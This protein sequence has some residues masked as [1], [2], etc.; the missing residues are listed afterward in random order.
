MTSNLYSNVE[1]TSK[2]QFTVGKVEAGIA[3]LLSPM[4]HLVEFPSQILPQ[5]VTTGSTVNITI[6]RNLIEEHRQLEEFETLQN[7]I[8]NTFTQ[9]P[10]PP[11]LSL[12]SVTQSSIVVEWTSLDLKHCTLHG[13]DIYKNG[14][15]LSIDIPKDATS[16]KI[17]GLDVAHT[18]DLWLIARTSAG[19]LTSNSIQVETH[20]MEN[21]TGITV[22]FGTFA[23]R[24]EVEDLVLLLDRIGAR[25]TDDL[26]INNTH[27]VC[28][29]PRGT[30]F[31]QAAEWNIPIV[32]P[33]F[34]KACEVNGR[35]QSASS[36]YISK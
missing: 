5:G 7:D 22:S 10:D 25:Y 32:G 15:K 23:N 16:Y 1:N 8:F 27:L 13:I 14:Q 9:E 35:I 33:E 6:D 18:Y 21:L 34:L 36:F 19:I 29:V 3:V 12:C 17:T 20:T 11:V 31:D 28:T 30:K 2:V 26:T 24:E 4:H